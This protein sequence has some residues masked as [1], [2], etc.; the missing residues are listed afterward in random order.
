MISHLFKRDLG[1]VILCPDRSIGGLRN[2]VNSIR[3]IIP[4]SNILCTVGNDVNSEE[5]ITM[6]NIC[7]TLQAEDTITSLI[8]L[9]LKEAKPDWNMLLFAGSFVRLG[10]YKKFDLFAKDEKDILFPVVN[11]KIDFVEGS[12]NGIILHK[13]TFKLV[14]DFNTSSMQKLGSNE[15]EMIKLFWAMSAVEHGCRFKA[16]VGMKVI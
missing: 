5:L 13:N 11:N 4:E 15:L 2:T 10:I 12:M 8:N 6:N 9:G 16:I 14:G 3:S 7:P 1:F